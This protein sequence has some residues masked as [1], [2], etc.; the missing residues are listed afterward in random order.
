MVLQGPEG[1]EGTEGTQVTEHRRPPSPAARRGQEG[2]RSLTS[3]AASEGQRQT[4]RHL[5]LRGAPNTGEQRCREL[6]PAWETEA[7]ARASCAHCGPPEGPGT[8]CHP[9]PPS[10]PRGG[11]VARPGECAPGLRAP[12]LRSLQR[13]GHA[14][15]AAKTRPPHTLHLRVGPAPLP[16]TLLRPPRLLRAPAGCAL[17]FPAEV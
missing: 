5:G 3:D 2:S 8:R 4:Q 11:L 6:K 7:H 16:H 17:E 10:T 15:G 9:A 14:H 13:Q 1:R 12:P